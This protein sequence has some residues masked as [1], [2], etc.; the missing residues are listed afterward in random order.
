MIG[1]LILAG[2]AIAAA[3]ATLVLLGL[4]HRAVAHN[5]SRD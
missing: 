2:L 1:G 5:A 4:L 3:G